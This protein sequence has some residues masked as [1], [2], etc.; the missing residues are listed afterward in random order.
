MTV[1]VGFVFSCEESVSLDCVLS[2]TVCP[3]VE[4]WFHCRPHLNNTTLQYKT[5]VVQ[6]ILGIINFCYNY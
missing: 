2:C 6:G 1:T 5:A 4:R 3:R